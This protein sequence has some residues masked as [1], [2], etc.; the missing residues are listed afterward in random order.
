MILEFILS[1]LFTVAYWFIH[2]LFSI[3]PNFDFISPVQSSLVGA[4]SWFLGV[5]NFM[6]PIIP[7]TVV[8]TCLTVY[9]LIPG[10]QQSLW[11][12]GLTQ[13]QALKI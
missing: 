1:I 12:F 5:V 8:I 3:I 10:F 11:A 6:S 2:L 4:F 9:I 7:S 13:F